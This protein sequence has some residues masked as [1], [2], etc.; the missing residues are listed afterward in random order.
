MFTPISKKYVEIKSGFF[1]LLKTIS[2]LNYSSTDE[3]KKNIK[4]YFQFFTLIN[5]HFFKQG[6]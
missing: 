2:D 1:Q 6:T 5:I 3:Y 4:N